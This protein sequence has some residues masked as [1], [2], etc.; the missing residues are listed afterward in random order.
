MPIF[1]KIDQPLSHA[2]DRRHHPITLTPQSPQVDSVMASSLISNHHGR[3]R[4]RERG[5]PKTTLKMARRYGMKERARRNCVKYTFRGVTFVYDAIRNKEVTCYRRKDARKRARN[6]CSG[7]FATVPILVSK[8]REYETP[9]VLQQHEK[10]RQSVCNAPE[11]WASHSVIWYV[12]ASCGIP[13]SA[14]AW[15]LTRLVVNHTIG[16]SALI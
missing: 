14:S 3:R 6:E 5:I 10:L 16:F 4:R 15:S 8:R 2:R 1:A 13:M 12:S 9:Q 11:R 7:T